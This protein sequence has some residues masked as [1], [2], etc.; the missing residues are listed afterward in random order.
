MIE[1]QPQSTVEPMGIIP[2]DKFIEL[3]DERNRQK[4]EGRADELERAY[5]DA[6][7]YHQGEIDYKL[8]HGENLYYLYTHANHNM[9]ITN[10]E[11]DKIIKRFKYQYLK[12]DDIVYV[13]FCKE[14]FEQVKITCMAAGYHVKREG[15]LFRET[16]RW[17]LIPITS[18]R[19]HIVK[20][21]PMSE[22]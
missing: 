13:F 15:F 16:I 17:R 20:L 22:L 6:I 14:V 4:A 5:H 1:H 7:T 3:R 10:H 2:A 11:I 18:E 21:E 19:E 8:R 9:F 12:E